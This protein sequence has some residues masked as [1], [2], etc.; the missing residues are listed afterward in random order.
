MK[1]FSPWESLSASSRSPI[2]S[3]SDPLHRCESDSF[4]NNTRGRLPSETGYKGYG[5]PLEN[6]CLH[7]RI[8]LARL[9][10]LDASC[11]YAGPDGSPL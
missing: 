1:S 6:T 10:R 2:L 8:A 5:C 4:E 3:L 11:R 9:G 7:I